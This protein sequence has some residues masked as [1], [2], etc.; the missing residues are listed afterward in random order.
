MSLYDVCYGEETLH[1]P[2]PET[3]AV[4]RYESHL[5]T[6]ETVDLSQRIREGL[7]EPSSASLIAQAS[8]IAIII[9]DNT[10]PTPSK[11]LLPLIIQ[12]IHD[13][14]TQ[15]VSIFIVVAL[16]AHKKLSHE[17]LT[18]LVGSEIIQNYPVLNH[19]AE[20]FAMLQDI[21]HT[22]HGTP[23]FVNKQVVQADLRILLGMIKPH[24]QA[25]YTGGGKAILPGVC[26]VE[27]IHANHSYQ[28]MSSIKSRVGVL[29]GNPIRSDI[30]HVLPLLGPCMLMNVVMD[31]HEHLV[32]LVVGSDVVATH[33]RGA[34]L[35]D[36][37]GKFPVRY[38]AD[39]C[40]CGTPAPVDMN[41][42]QMLNSL[43]CPHRQAEPIVKKGGTIV[44]YGRAAEG[45]SD[46]DL[47]KAL[48]QTPR[49]TLHDQVFSSEPSFRDRPALQIFL[50]CEQ[51]YRIIV[52]TELK[53]L[54][55]FA[56]MGIEAYS[57]AQH[58]EVLQSIVYHHGVNPKCFVLADAPY[59]ILD[60][61]TTRRNVCTG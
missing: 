20:N 31:R 27:T 46:A 52:V 10:R 30:D 36:T 56:N 13:R 3:F 28:Y 6:E 48:A 17:E 22:D 54:A 25:G 42:Y 35:Y 41:F 60:N 53:N 34:A 32:D 18:Q 33:K 14:A 16:G 23:V 12:E 38:L 7:C 51:Q 11:R 61:Q 24:N 1:I 47:Y 50:E 15:K 59:V 45:V 49:S 39:V 29:D 4:E 26:A 40:L 2:L 8:S 21:G 57:V 44:V 55:L 5:C 19:E 37:F 43:S 58:E 9:D